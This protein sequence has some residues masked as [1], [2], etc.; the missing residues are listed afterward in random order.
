LC[1]RNKGFK[2][3]DNEVSIITRASEMLIN[4]KFYEQLGFKKEEQFN[5]AIKIIKGKLYEN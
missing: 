1:K 4:P 2:F 3:D 5:K